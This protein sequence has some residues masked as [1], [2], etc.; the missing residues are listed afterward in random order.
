[1]I[2]LACLIYSRFL[3]EGF[4]RKSKRLYQEKQNCCDR[5][6]GYFG[7]GYRD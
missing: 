4:S 1:M 6:G 3:N 7:S 2:K 5:F